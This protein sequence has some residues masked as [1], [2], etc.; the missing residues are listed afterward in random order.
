MKKI[1]IRYVKKTISSAIISGLLAYFLFKTNDLFSKIVISLFLVF[2]IS[3][4]VKNVCLI[5]NKNKLAK[6]FSKVNV[7]AFLI[8]FFGF[9][10]MW[11]YT[12]LKNGGYLQ[13]LFSIPFWLVGIYIVK[14]RLFNQKD[15]IN[16]EK[17]NTKTKIRIDFR[18]LISA[19]LVGIV[20]VSGIVMLFFGIRDTY[21]LN[22]KTKGYITAI[23]YFNNYD[24]FDVDDD[25]I[26]YKLTYI[27]T[28]D[29]KEYSITTDY[30][31]NYIPEENSSR[32][33]KY[34]PN[35]PEEAV[36][37][38][39]NSKNGLI[40]GGAFFT[41]GSLTFIIAALTVLGY[42]DKF[43]IDILGTYIGFLFLT[44]GLGIILFQTGTTMSLLETIKSFGLLIA[45]P[46]MF[47]VVGIIQIIK[48]LVKK[49]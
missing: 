30:G 12:S 6:I 31:T 46:I 38:G 26:T 43:K 41:F 49:K 5:L 23:G 9:I 17:S 45:I 24:V 14:K 42:F 47:I 33:I 35:N 27:Y 36:I 22:I 39:T 34:N 19:L 20:F 44:I 37:I 7:V 2:G 16:N 4:F 1:N 13:T 48:C 25:G 10:I 11:C 21:K 15:K 18:I 28:V 29:D 32:E 40:Y 3:F 8:Y